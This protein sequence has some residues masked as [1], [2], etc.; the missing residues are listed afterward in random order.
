MSSAIRSIVRYSERNG[1]CLTMKRYKE[2]TKKRR[3]LSANALEVRHLHHMRNYKPK[4]E[5]AVER[6]VAAQVQK[7]IK[8]SFMQKMKNL[9]RRGK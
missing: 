6:K 8:L 3:R 1:G 9:F 7:E 5:A 2:D 4:Q